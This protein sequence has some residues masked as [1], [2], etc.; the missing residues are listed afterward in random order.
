[1]RSSSILR[2][3][4]A[5][6]AGLLAAALPAS[7]APAGADTDDLVEKAVTEA[8]TGELMDRAKR[9]PGTAGQVPGAATVSI[10]RRAGTRWAFGTGVLRAPATAQAYPE[11]WL[12]L[13]ERTGGTWQVSFEGEPEFAGFA[14][15]A[16]ILDNAEADA[17][18]ATGEVSLMYAN[19]DYRTGMRL[20]YGLGASWY[21]TGGP[22]GSPVRNAVDLAGGDRVVRAARG[23]RAY[24]MCRGWVRVVHDRGY[25]T[26]YYHLWNNINVNGAS[27]AAGAR[28]GDTGTDVTCGGSATGRHVHFGLRQYGEPVPIARHI[29]GKWTPYNGSAQYA[30]YALHGSRRQNV[31]GTLYNYGPLGFTQGIVD[32]HGGSYVNKRSGPG[33]GYRIVGTAA[34]GAT[35]SVSCSRNG[36][37]HT[38]RFGTTSLWDKLTDGTWISDAYLE[39][40]VSGPV[41]GWC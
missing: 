20:P 35:V 39:N 37:S 40:G 31:G 7:P 34:D 4:A 21:L 22:H 15:R 11:G 12:F 38:G 14:R 2:C 28:L 9:L 29:I 3:A 1:M 25:A 27:V 16:P 18:A 26:D 23:G 17:L 13:A 33:T 24:T 6:S 8:V 32:S 30:G 41:N 10:T 19:R 36:T 5:G